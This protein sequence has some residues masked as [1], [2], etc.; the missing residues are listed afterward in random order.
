MMRAEYAKRE[1]GIDSKR[2]P[3]DADAL[4]MVRE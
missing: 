4:M 2:W 1:E 3:A